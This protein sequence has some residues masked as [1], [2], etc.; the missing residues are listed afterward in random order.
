MSVKRASLC[1]GGPELSEI[2]FGTWR[3]LNGEPRP[4]TPDI[5]RLLSR[6]LELGITTI[7]TAEIYGRYEVEKALGKALAETA[8]FR[9][10]FDIVTKCG[11]D[12]PS[13]EKASARLPHYNATADNIVACAEKSLR[14]L[15]VDALDL[16]LVHRPD[17]LTPAEETAA[18]LNRLLDAGKIRFAGVSNY[19]KNQFELLAACL[20]RPLATNQVE[21]SLFNMDALYDGTLAQCERHKTRPMAWSVLGGGELFSAGNPAAARIRQAMEEMRDR[22]EGAGDDALATAWVM[23]HP[24]RPIAI[25]GSNKM[26][27]IESQARAAAIELDRQDWYALWSA[28]KGHPIP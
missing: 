1:D 19:T 6:C 9:G 13:A 3:L 27:R 5:V 20:D 12:V 15:G 18:G 25:T 14:L 8:S 11:I 28:A 17:W 21:I 23:R 7:D 24:S 16:L 4:S 22:Y 2:A 26:V 10:A